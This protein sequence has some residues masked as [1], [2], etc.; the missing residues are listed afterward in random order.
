MVH[1]NHYDILV[2]PISG[3]GFLA[4]A[5]CLYKLMIDKKDYRADICLAS[6]GGNVVSYGLLSSGHNSSYFLQ[7]MKSLKTNNYIKSNNSTIYNALTKGVLFELASARSFFDQYIT[8]SI[9]G[10]IE[11]WTGTTNVTRSKITNF[12]NLASD[13]SILKPSLC[14]LRC[15]EPK[16]LDCDTDRIKSVFEASVSIPVCF[17]SVVIDGE[18][19][20]DGGNIDASP[21]SSLYNE[22]SELES[23][24]MIYIVSDNFES[25][26]DMTSKNILEHAMSSIGIIVRSIMAKDTE[27]ARQILGRSEQV[28]ISSI[29]EYFNIR[30]NYKK[31]NLIIRPFGYKDI[32]LFNFDFSS[33]M[34]LFYSTIHSITLELTVQI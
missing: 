7:L 15:T 30:D 21:L 24:H 31:T 26:V 27:I 20:Q 8:K 19:Y 18:K 2:L 12:C 33:E 9:V 32:D 28:N 4:Q 23:Y 22:V 16:Y 17:D 10:E 3:G 11:I 14:N 5:A 25:D 29:E 1:S 13:K 6:S 34:E